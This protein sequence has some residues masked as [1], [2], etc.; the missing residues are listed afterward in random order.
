MAGN[1]VIES[2]KQNARNVVGPYAADRRTDPRY[3]FSAHAELVEDKSGKR[4]ET[5]VDDLSRRGCYLNTHMPSPL[6]TAA[7]V[8]IMKETQCFEANAKVV[9]S[10]AG[11]GMGLLFADVDPEQQLILTAWLTGSLENSGLDSGR[12]RSRRVTVRIPVHVSGKNSIGSQFEEETYTQTLS[13][14]G[15][16][17]FLSTNVIKGQPITLSNSPPNGTV[18]CTVAHIGEPQGDLLQVGVTFVLPNQYQLFWDAT[19]PSLD[20]SKRSL[21][22]KLA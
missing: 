17:I 10:M 5:C 18:K 11:K 19:F 16:L 4:I 13:A 12:R 22:T 14:H 15:A 6:Y 9:S 20:W 2:K 8:R 3:K 21:G 1:V 7:S